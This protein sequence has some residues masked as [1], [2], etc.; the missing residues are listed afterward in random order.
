MKKYKR[1]IIFSKFLIKSFYELILFPIFY[2]PGFF[3]EKLRYNYYRK[4][5]KYLGENVKIDVGVSIINPEYISI[6]SNTWIDKHVILLAG[7]PMVGERKIYRKSNKNYTG[8]EGELIIANDIHISAF[9][10]ISGMGGTYIG[11]GVA[12]GSRIF[13]FSHHYRNLLDL[14]DN[15]DYNFSSMSPQKEQALISGPVVLES[16]SAIGLNSVLLPGVTIGKNSWIGAGS[17]VHKNI[18]AD[19]IASGNP[20]KVIK[21]KFW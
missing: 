14:S 4:K 8:E 19:V 11:G 5:M 15:Y 13:S 10:I 7:K 20:V 16:N 6:G 1:L 3:G 17:V 9:T 12:A 21:K 2:V 18:P